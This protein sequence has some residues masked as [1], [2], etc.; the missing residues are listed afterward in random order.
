MRRPVQ[1]QRII[2]NKSYD[3]LYPE[4]M[5]RNGKKFD[6]ICDADMKMIHVCI[7]EESN[8]GNIKKNK[9]ELL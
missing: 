3:E 8:N 4:D 5:D 7:K 6:L 2:W 9:K 1:N